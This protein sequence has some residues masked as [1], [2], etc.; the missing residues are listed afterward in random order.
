MKK[1]FAMSTQNSIK[2]V[3]VS[4]LEK[5]RQSIVSLHGLLGCQGMPHF[6]TLLRLQV[7][8]INVFHPNETSYQIVRRYADFASFHVSIGDF[9]HS[10]RTFRPSEINGY[11]YILA[12]G[13]L[14]E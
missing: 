12:E 10:P 1:L 13:H 3:L 14:V 7:F 5:R 8:V 2:K 4:S 9:T 6:D 11:A